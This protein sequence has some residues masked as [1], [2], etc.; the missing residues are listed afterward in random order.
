MLK[1]KNELQNFHLWAQIH[2][3]STVATICRGAE[4][5]QG[6]TVVPG[7]SQAASVEN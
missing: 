4:G 7:V 2:C 5:E 1:P 3:A 6:Q